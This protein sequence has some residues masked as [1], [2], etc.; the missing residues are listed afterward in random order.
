[1]IK[2][3]GSK[4]SL[5]NWIVDTARQIHQF[6]PLHTVVDLFSGSARVAHAFKARGYFVYA[7]D[8]NTYAYVLA[9][10]LVEANR[11][12]YP[13]ETV[14]PVLDALMQLPP[15][16]GWF[17][18]RYCEEARY[19]M[20]E[21]GAR[22]EAIRNA[23]ERYTDPHLRAI[24]LTSLMLAA[25]KVDSTTGLQMAYLK[26]W[27][28]RAYNPLM[29]R[30]PPLLPGEGKAFQADA[31][32]LAGQLEADLFYLDPPYNQHSYL[33]NYHVWE[34]LVLWD[35]PETYG[36]ARKRV[37]V[38][39]RKSVFNSRAQARDAM[40]HLVHSIRASHLLVSFNNEGYL[41]REELEQI[42][43]EWGYVACFE[44][45]Y[46]RYVGA[47]I[48][49][50]NP[51]GEKVGQVSHTRNKEMLFVATKSRAVAEGLGIAL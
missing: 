22:I 24:L 5:I 17:T 28:P 15:T 30:Y 26:E 1:M 27:A 40:A 46:R 45:P 33:A 18:Q 7:N 34:T 47:L 31:L 38:K 9:T 8:H 32:E 10:A 13:P 11:D 49:I 20:P 43:R 50:Y 6:A 4:R 23:I 2:Y 44:R 41:T 14:Q 25:D 3:L 29:L 16:H 35:N 37:D 21:N 48:G 51:Q 12:R 39:C 42:L 36:V 19:F